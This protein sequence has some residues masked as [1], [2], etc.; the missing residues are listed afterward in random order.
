MAEGVSGPP[1]LLKVVGDMG[2]FGDFGDLGADDEFERSCRGGRAIEGGGAAL[3]VLMLFAGCDD[4]D[5]VVAVAV[6]VASAVVGEDDFGIPLGEF[7]ALP[8]LLIVVGRE[9]EG[10]WILRSL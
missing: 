2:D 5:G 6:V 10:S 3:V 8:P 9:S 4:D 7:G 1:L